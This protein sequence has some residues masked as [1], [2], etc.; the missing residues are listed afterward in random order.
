MPKGPWSS[1]RLFGSRLAM[2][3]NQLRFE[4]H[5]EPGGLTRDLGL[6][7]STDIFCLAKWKSY[8]IGYFAFKKLGDSHKYRGFCFLNNQISE[9]FELYSHMTII[10]QLK[11]SSGCPQVCYIRDLFLSSALL[12]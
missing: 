11:I 7:W 8:E 12:T 6:I 10:S 1:D 9:V 3:G 4:E 5:A 2:E